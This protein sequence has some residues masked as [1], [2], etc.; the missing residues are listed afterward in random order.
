MNGKGS[1]NRT[2]DREAYRRNWERVFMKKQ[3]WERDRFKMT[4]DFVNLVLMKVRR[5]LGNQFRLMP[6]RLENGSDLVASLDFVNGDQILN[7]RVAL[8]RLTM[9]WCPTNEE[10]A[11][12]VVAQVMKAADDIREFVRTGG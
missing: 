1:R 2:T 11:R 5:Q 7:A 10:A 12:Y 8:D 9:A 6:L 4:E 3:P